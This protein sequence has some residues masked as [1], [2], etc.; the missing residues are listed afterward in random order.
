MS[1]RSLQSRALLQRAV[2]RA[3]GVPALRRINAAPYALAFGL[4]TRLCTRTPGVAGAFVRSGMARQGWTP[5]LSDVDL[6]VVLDDGL[7]A[8]E[9][10]RTALAVT[11]SYRRLRRGLPML[12]ELEVVTARHLAARVSYGVDAGTAA[13]WPRLGNPPPLPVVDEPALSSALGPLRAYR[14]H[15][16]PWCWAERDGDPRAPFVRGRAIAKLRRT[17]GVP[18]AAGPDDRTP[19]ELLVVGLTALGGALARPIVAE[20]AAPAYRDALVGSEVTAASATTGLSESSL[21]ALDCIVAP[22]K[23]RGRVYAVLSDDADNETRQRCVADVLGCFDSPVIVDRL[24][25]AQLL[26]TVDPLEHFGLLQRRTILH[27]RDPLPLPYGLGDGTLRSSVLGYAV[28]MLGYPYS[29]EWQKLSSRAFSDMLLG[30][31]VRTAA[32]LVDDVMEMTFDRQR[33]YYRSRFPD[34]AAQVDPDLGT[35][36]EERRFTVLRALTDEIWRGMRQADATAVAAGA[37]SSPSWLTI[38]SSPIE[39]SHD[40]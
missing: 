12:G 26:L 23:A 33:A 34:L 35:D 16:L 24:V 6:L 10:R 13:S 5:G 30:W 25:L 27:G 2:I 21:E 40:G 38:T 8:V 7:S 39:T 11:R 32:Y 36:D 19:A 3:N 9:E 22:A 14:Y 4:L 31:F 15:L 17:L 29:E 18:A 20:R 1:R 37:S 28:D